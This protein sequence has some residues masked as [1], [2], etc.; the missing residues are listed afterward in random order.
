[1]NIS[2]WFRPLI[3]SM[4]GRKL[5]YLKKA[6][7]TVLITRGYRFFFYVN[8][9]SPAHIHVEKDRGT[10]KFDSETTGG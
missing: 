5:L 7:P 4:N 8:D 10:A 9:H 2:V 3:M 1:M 6:M